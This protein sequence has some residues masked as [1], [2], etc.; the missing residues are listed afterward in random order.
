MA[1]LVAPDLLRRLADLAEQ[2][3][4]LLVAYAKG[5]QPS[6]HSGGRAPVDVKDLCLHADIHDHLSKVELSALLAET[7]VAIPDPPAAAETP[8]PA[9][10]APAAPEPA[11]AVV[12]CHGE[13]S[14]LQEFA[15][16]QAAKLE[17]ERRNP[18]L[19]ELPARA[20]P[21][22]IADPLGGLAVAPLP[23]P[24]ASHGLGG[25]TALV[26]GG[27]SGIGKAISVRL[28]REGACVVV[29]DTRREPR[30]GGPDVMEL[31]LRAR[32]EHGAPAAYDRFVQGSTHRIEGSK[33]RECY[34]CLASH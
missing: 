31:M 1:S 27:A 4:A 5:S 26:T 23:A 32:L 3:R 30:E 24:M 15:A 2:K 29:L 18:Q 28:A 19:P 16:R 14:S 20:P 6:A 21:A 17:E 11:S 7:Q 34:A 25:T 33:M 12:P 9:D 10:P 22:A 13:A 8:P